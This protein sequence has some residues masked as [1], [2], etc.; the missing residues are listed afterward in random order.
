MLVNAGDW[1]LKTIVLTVRVRE[2]DNTANAIISNNKL[3]I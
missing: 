3:H 1:W 2:A